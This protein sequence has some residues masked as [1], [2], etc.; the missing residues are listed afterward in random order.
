MGT[1]HNYKQLA[2]SITIGGNINVAVWGALEEEH[3][4]GLVTYAEAWL[5][6]C[7]FE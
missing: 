6:C 3:A 7:A 5:C 4:K 1:C 2:T